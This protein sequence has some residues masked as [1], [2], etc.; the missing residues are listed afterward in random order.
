VPLWTRAN[1]IGSRPTRS[2]SSCGRTSASRGRPRVCGTLTPTLAPTPTPAPAPTLAP[3]P[4][5]TL[6]LALALTLTLAPT[7]TPTLT[8]A[9]ALTLTRARAFTLALTLTRRAAYV[10]V[11]SAYFEGAISL[12]ILVNIVSMTLTYYGESEQHA[13]T[14]AAFN[15]CF[16]AIFAVEAALKIVAYFPRQVRVRMTLTLTLAPAR[17]SSPYFPRQVRVRMTLTPSRSSSP[18]PPAVPGG[19]MEPLRR[20]TCARLGG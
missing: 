16:S 8:L 4:T 12:T 15:L 10:V 17:S 9:L 20:A 19:P 6:T 18:T 14:L 7:P 5:P 11:E 2:C 1:E 13:A 3:T